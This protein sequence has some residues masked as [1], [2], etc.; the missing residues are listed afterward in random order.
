M[1]DGLESGSTHILKMINKQQSIEQMEKA[2]RWANEVGIAVRGMFMVGN[3]GETK[4]TLEETIAFVKRN[5]IKD[6]HVTFFTPL[7]GTPSFVQW[8][9]YGTWD[10]GTTEGSTTS[11]HFATFLPNGW[12]RDDLVLYQKR[13]YTAFIKPSTLWYHLK[14]F[15][16]PSITFFMLRGG[17]AYVSY[18]FSQKNSTPPALRPDH[19]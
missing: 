3:F 10:V 12:S 14:K 6:F 13:L 19:T 11:M 17:L 18:V 15:F 16:R 1:G 9:R 7:P 8:K 2:I 4:E 5:P